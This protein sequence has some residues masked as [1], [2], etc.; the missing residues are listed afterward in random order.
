MM[1]PNPNMSISLND[2]EIQ[3]A[4]ELAYRRFDSCSNEN[5]INRKVI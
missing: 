2:L 4:N 3:V 5:V 1:L